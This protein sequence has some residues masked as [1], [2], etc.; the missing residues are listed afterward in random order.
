[1]SGNDQFLPWLETYGSLVFA[2]RA[3]LREHTGPVFPVGVHIYAAHLGR[4]TD[5]LHA[6]HNYEVGGDFIDDAGISQVAGDAEG[7]YPP[8]HQGDVA[9]PEIDAKQVGIGLL[10]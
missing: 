2:A 3:M 9:I 5:L 8:R 10:V 1:M 6:T 7:V 4:E